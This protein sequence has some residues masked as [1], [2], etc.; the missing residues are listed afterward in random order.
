M[1]DVSLAHSPSQGI[2]YERVAAQVALQ[3]TDFQAIRAVQAIHAHQLHR[4]P[5]LVADIFMGGAVDRLDGT[6]EYTSV[7][8]GAGPNEHGIGA[9]IG[10]HGRQLLRAI[11]PPPD[12]CAPAGDVCT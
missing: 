2:V 8:A 5:D 9:G 11:V 1:T 6:C 4:E 10:L 3:P 12:H 7:G